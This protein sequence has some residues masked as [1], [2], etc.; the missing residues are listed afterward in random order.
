MQPPI[1]I[2]TLP[3]YLAF[4]IFAF[5][6]LIVMLLGLILGKILSRL[7]GPHKKTPF[8]DETFE[9]GQLPFSVA[10]DHPLVGAT[11]YF[12]YAVAF[13]V[14]DAFAWMLLASTI[15]TTTATWVALFVAFYVIITLAGLYYLLKFIS[16]VIT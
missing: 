11:R 5:L 16:E 10:Q 2:F 15:A 12:V 3:D 8:K 9:C 4:W 1:P 6:F 7:Y 13:F 14:V